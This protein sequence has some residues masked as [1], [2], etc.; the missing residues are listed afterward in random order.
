MVH[1]SLVR[2]ETPVF[3]EPKRLGRRDRPEFDR[4]ELRAGAEYRES[5]DDSYLGS[6]RRVLCR[7]SEVDPCLLLLRRL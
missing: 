6:T 3:S 7:R 1:C 2:R 4:D 5:L